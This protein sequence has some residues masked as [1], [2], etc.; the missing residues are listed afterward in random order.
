RQLGEI[1][2]V[3]STEAR[4]VLG[5]RPADDL[6]FAA[7][8]PESIYHVRSIAEVETQV[9]K[10]GLYGTQTTKQELSSNLCAWT[11]AYKSCACIS[12]SAPLMPDKPMS[13]TQ[14]S[15]HDQPDSCAILKPDRATI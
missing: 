10:A 11:L 8:F 13:I 7:E 4:I 1:F 2:R 3:M 15:T 12:S 9:E 5:Y 6:G 14:F